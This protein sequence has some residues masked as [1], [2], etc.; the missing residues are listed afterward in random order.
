M[1]RFWYIAMIFVLLAATVIS[2]GKDEETPTPAAPVSGEGDQVGAAGALPGAAMQ[3][4][5]ERG[6][7]PDDIN[8][9]LMTYTPKIGRA[10]V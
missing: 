9:A 10:H 3:I 1:R 2:C 8:A 5:Q 7:T 6:L 4:A